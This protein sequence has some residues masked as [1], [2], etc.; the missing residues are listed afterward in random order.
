MV[1]QRSVHPSCPTCDVPMW[2]VK[3]E[4]GDIADRQQFECKVCDRTERRTVRHE[5]HAA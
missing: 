4:I 3:V 2:L 1:D 5:Q